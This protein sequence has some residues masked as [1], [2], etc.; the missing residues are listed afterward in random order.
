MSQFT[1]PASLL[2]A[3][4]VPPLLWWWLRQRRSAVRHPVAGL[5]AAL[6]AGRARWARVGGATLRAAALL[7][8]VVAVAGPRWPDLNTPVETE[9]I[10]IVLAVDVSGSMAEQDFDWNGTAIAR[11]EA[12]KRVFRLFVTGGEV[13]P[14]GAPLRFEGRPTDLLGMVT[15]GTRAEV[16]CPLTL[17]HSALVRMLDEE[18]PRRAAGESQTNLSDA[19]AV[20]LQ[21]LKSARPRRKVL[22]LLTD[23]EHNQVSPPSGWTPRQSAQ[24]SGSLGIPIYAIDAGGS[25]GSAA[26]GGPAAVRA[27]A[28]QTLKDVAKISQGRYFTA[29]DTGA[30]LAA[31]QEID[32]LERD[33]IETQQF[34]RYH[35]LYSWFALS[36]FVLLALALAL[37]R[38]IWRRL[39]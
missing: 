1:A 39:P 25:L 18:Q 22:V 2:L 3:L 30:L 29:R 21:R 31:C 5:L 34:R 12:V 38:T 8:L 27:D 26:E 15:F 14:Q 28:E 33:R 35:E 13:G 23:G 24:V 17:S 11:L 6:P 10:A 19:I 36:S 20:G 4:A 16:A 9:G 32:R 37:D 7:A